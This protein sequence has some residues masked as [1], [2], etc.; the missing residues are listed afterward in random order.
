M[1]HVYLIVLNNHFTGKRHSN[2]LEL[3]PI[4]SWFLFCPWLEK[5]VRNIHLVPDMVPENHFGVRKFTR[6]PLSD[7]SVWCTE[8]HDNTIRVDETFEWSGEPQT[9]SG[10]GWSCLLCN[11]LE[12]EHSGA[13]SSCSRPAMRWPC[14]AD[15]FICV[16]DVSILLK[17]E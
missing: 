17:S 4:L 2:C 6:T 10:W 11:A 12:A 8:M 13:C 15:V 14:S 5:G 3:V 16:G 9:L 7:A 1:Y